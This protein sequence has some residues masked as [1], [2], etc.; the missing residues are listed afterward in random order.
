VGTGWTP[1]RERGKDKMRRSCGGYWP[2]KRPRRNAPRKTKK[3]VTEVKPPEERGYV[4]DALVETSLQ[5]PG[6]GERGTKIPGTFMA[7]ATAA[8]GRPIIKANG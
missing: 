2:E 8:F 5:G 6:L 4:D 3:G 1:Q 7:G